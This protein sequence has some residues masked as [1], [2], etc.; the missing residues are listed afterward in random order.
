[1]ALILALARPAAAGDGSAFER[2][3]ALAWPHYRDA[4]VQSAE[5]D[6]ATTTAAL[7]AFTAAW[8]RVTGEAAGDLPP[9]FRG[10]PGASSDLD[11]IGAIADKAAEQ[12]RRGRLAQAHA[13]LQQIRAILSELRR[14]N[15]VATYDDPIDEFEEKLAE[16]GDNDFDQAE[17]PPDQFI[18]LV[19]QLG[20][21]AYLV[22][23]LE[24]L[25]P[26]QW[27]G[28]PA[29]LESAEG[30]ARQ[31]ATVKAALFTGQS[32]AVRAAFED[33]RKHFNKFY[34]YYG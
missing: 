23:R 7:N 12:A 22:E 14:R 28:D 31:V 20:V 6:A 13:T 29:F 24:K 26:P 34:L 18:Q 25:V 1:M 2:D 16:A 19:E 10:D 3:F 4:W 33:L 11:L 8:A 32:L 15:G 27:V 9:A 5:T 17:I 21:L 30:L